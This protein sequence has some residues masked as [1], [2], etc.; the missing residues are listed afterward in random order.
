MSLF[1]SNLLK[2]IRK[3]PKFLKFVKSNQYYSIIFIRVLI[4][5]LL[6]RVGLEVVY[7]CLELL[8]RMGH[9]V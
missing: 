5:G 6:L 8:L 1:Q 4:L 9:K 3:L 2:Q 7:D